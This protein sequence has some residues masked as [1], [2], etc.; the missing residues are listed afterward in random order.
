MI[1]RQCMPCSLCLYVSPPSTSSKD[2]PAAFPTLARVVLSLHRLRNLNKGDPPVPLSSPMSTFPSSSTSSPPS[3]PSSLR[4]RL[5][6]DEDADHT[7]VFHAEPLKRIE[8]LVVSFRKARIA[9]CVRDDERP[10]RCG[11]GVEVE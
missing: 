6:D 5:L 10:K 8:S 7:H 3:C 9:L 1:R 4:M 2:G 11:M